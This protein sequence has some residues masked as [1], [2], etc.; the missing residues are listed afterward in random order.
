MPKSTKSN[1]TTNS[2]VSNDY[3]NICLCLILSVLFGYLHTVHIEQLFENDKHFSH[4]SNLERELSFRTESGLYYYYFKILVVDQN[5]QRTNKS[6]HSLIST[7]ILS[8][9]RT[10]YPSTINSLKRF[11]LY[12][13]IVL[14]CAYRFMNW[15]NLLEKSCWQ[16]DRGN[17]PSI[18]SCVGNL[19][20]IYFY[21]KSVFI[22]NGFSMAFLFILCWL[23]NN[24]SIISGI[25]GCLCFFYNHSEATRVMWTPALR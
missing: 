5:Q 15:L 21:V 25:I 13:E 19:E 14:A 22:L 10:E 18:E 7:F 2:K 11:N 4:L 8:D 9:N 1:N 24:R 17:M 6:L 16:I 20:P 12:P 23:L 3:L